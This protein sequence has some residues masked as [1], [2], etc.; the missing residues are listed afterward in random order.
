MKLRIKIFRLDIWSRPIPRTRRR[1]RGGLLQRTV[2]TSVG[3]R[4]CCRSRKSRSHRYCRRIVKL[5]VGW[6]KVKGPIRMILNDKKR[7]VRSRRSFNSKSRRMR[8]WI[9]LD[10][11]LLRA[12]Q[13]M[14]PSMMERIHSGWT[15][16]CSVPLLV[17]VV[18]LTKTVMMMNRW[19]WPAIKILIVPMV[20]LLV[21]MA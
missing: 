3:H 15:S 7:R 18:T 2:A 12:I 20:L 6:W 11:H 16:I 5:P 9:N 13:T 10:R 1:R 17:T 21:S 4:C 14:P 19:K 8:L